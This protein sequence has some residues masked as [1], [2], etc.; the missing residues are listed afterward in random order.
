MKDVFNPK[1]THPNCTKIANYALPG[2]LR[3]V[4]CVTHISEGMKNIKDPMCSTPGCDTRPSF[5]LRGGRPECCIDHA[6]NMMVDLISKRCA[7]P[8][9]TT[10][11]SFG[12]PGGKS[13]FCGD[14]ATAEMVPMGQKQC[15]HLDCKKQPSYNFRGETE[16]IVCFV[17][18][19]PEMINVRDPRCETEGCD[20]I[21]FCA[22]P[23]HTPVSCK[24]H[25]VI[26]TMIFNPRARCCVRGCTQQAMYGS[27]VH[28]LERCEIHLEPGD[29][30]LAER[31]CAKCKTS[32]ILNKD[33]LCQNCDP[34][35]ISRARLAKQNEVFAFLDLH[36]LK[37]TYADDRVI[38]GGACGLQRP[39]RIYELPER[40]FVL[41]V[42]ENQHSSYVRK[43]ER[44]RMINVSQA[45]GGK[46]VFWIRFNPDAYKR[47]AEADGRKRSRQCPRNQ[48]LKCLERVIRTAIDAPVPVPGAFISVLY[49]Y[50]DGYVD[51]TGETDWEVITEYETETEVIHETE[52]IQ[53]FSIMISIVAADTVL[54]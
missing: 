17:H 30:N 11:P 6:S 43:C 53:T 47:T 23:G 27:T 12:L 38:D 46:P 4:R 29:I 40:V 20:A 9:C 15:S 1:C 37:G 22:R 21:A 2:A 50:Y 14:H 51:G 26:G 36:G 13:E 31:E 3:P 49:L 52:V 24:R 16:P 19:D 54:C 32:Y 33:N 25:R 35:A 48:R 7:H 41:E 18:K 34:V 45:F 39:D 10:R 44:D 42:D 8:E 28:K 5:G